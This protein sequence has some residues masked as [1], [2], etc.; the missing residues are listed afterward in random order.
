MSRRTRAC[1]MPL[2][3]QADA[4]AWLVMHADLDAAVYSA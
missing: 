3:D 2:V 4:A 1:V